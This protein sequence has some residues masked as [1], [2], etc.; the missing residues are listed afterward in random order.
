MTH[1]PRRSPRPPSRP[2]RNTLLVA[3][4]GAI[5][6]GCATDPRTG[7]PS[8]QETFASDD[9]CSNNARNIGI[10]LGAL[11]GAILGNQ[12]KHSNGARL[13]G[14]AAGAA[15][16]GLIGHDMDQR[17]CALSK[18]AKQYNL[19]LSVATVSAS[20]EVLDDARLRGDRNAAQ[21]QASAVGSVV[22]V[23]DQAEAGGHFEPNSDQL[24]DKAQRYF[25]A[26]ADTYNS[27][28]LAAQIRD[29]NE[30]AAY[31]QQIEKRKILLVGH[32]DDTGSSRL[33]ADLSERRAQAVARYIEARGIPRASLYFQGA[34]ESYPIADNNSDSGRAQ[35][36][37]V[38]IVEIADE[39][40]F[41]RFL[42]ARRPRYD[43]Y[44]AGAVAAT[45]AV[46]VAAPV[47]SK[48]AGPGATAVATTAPAAPPSGARSSPA[49]ARN[50]KP[51]AVAVAAGTGTRSGPK[52]DA[53]AGLDFGG[54]PL[55]QSA[56][57][58]S[59]GRGAGGDSYFS[60]I[61][62]A[63]ADEAPP[64][65]DCTR[66]RP[67]ATNGVKALSDG[68][69][70]RTSDY[71]PGLYGKTWTEQVNGH[72]VVL[73][74]VAVLASDGAPANLPEFKV[75]ANFNAAKS[76]NPT[77][78]LSFTPAVNT[79]LGEKGVLYRMFLDGRAGLQC[80]DVVFANGGGVQA[81]AGK[82]VYSHAGQDYATPFT[83]RVYQQ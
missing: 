46:P 76:R 15:A 10:G 52:S 43:L 12:V 42:A 31:I 41:Q 28:I 66:D 36:R 2:A 21:I 69:S 71:F 79:F 3:L 9:P 14:A 23:R 72:Q 37:R 74:K 33:N 64:I 80:V 26:I 22:Q 58:A 55:A 6:A 25:S 27:R 50:G 56:A 73:N 70:Y 48:V 51:G 8:F 11:A 57:L 61:S 30:R 82:L 62:S 40:S 35:N 16:G 53:G 44:R 83:P 38:E 20:G 19:D 81:K 75:Y 45:P 49:G 47:G 32:T 67:R 18:I 78:E 5:A 65:A 54:K 39:E 1:T 60:L 34:G 7:Q 24:T 63:Y 13:L 59:V 4:C 29:P 77:P 17:R 68:K